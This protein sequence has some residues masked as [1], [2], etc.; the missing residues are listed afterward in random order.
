MAK[1]REYLYIPQDFHGQSITSGES[2]CSPRGQPNRMNP[3][4]KI[5]CLSVASDEISSVGAG[6]KLKTTDETNKTK[7]RKEYMCLETQ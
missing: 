7:C 6:V 5:S 1:N 2:T 3:V 4:R